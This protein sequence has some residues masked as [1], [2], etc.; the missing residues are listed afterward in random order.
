MAADSDNR[1]R[2]HRVLF[3]HTAELACEA[4]RVRV[5]LLDVSLKGALVDMPQGAPQLP[6]GHGCEL[7]IWLSAEVHIAMQCVVAWHR[8]AS[9]GLVCRRIDLESMQHLRRLMELNL[10]D[11][12]LLERELAALGAWRST[13]DSDAQR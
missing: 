6:E 11:D 1:R 10:G 5:H 12:E 8:E 13:D 9:V 4:E 3:D 2:F 7:V